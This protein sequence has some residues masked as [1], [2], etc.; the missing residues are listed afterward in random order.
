MKLFLD[1]EF[2]SPTRHQADLPGL[3]TEAGDEYY[4][5]LTGTYLV[6]CSELEIENVLPQLDLPKHGKTLAEAQESLPAFPAQR[7]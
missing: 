3:V 2:L 4:D 6:D 5:A 7:Q 1:C